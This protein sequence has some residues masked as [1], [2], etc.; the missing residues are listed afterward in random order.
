M[1]DTSA[2]CEASARRLRGDCDREREVEEVGVVGLEGL[3]GFG[4]LQAAAMRAAV[5]GQA[6]IKLKTPWREGALDD[7]H[8]KDHGDDLQFA[9]AVGA[10]LHVELEVRS[11]HPSQVVACA[12]ADPTVSSPW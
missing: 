6:E 10:V 7:R 12:L 5:A 9:A 11:E 4:E 1:I 3:V 2:V 8:P